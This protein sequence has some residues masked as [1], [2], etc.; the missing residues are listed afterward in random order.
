VLQLRPP[1]PPSRLD[2]AALRRVARRV[3]TGPP[4]P[5]GG[6]DAGPAPLLLSRLLSAASPVPHFPR[7]P[8]RHDSAVSW[9]PAARAADE[10][11][12][13]AAV[14]KLLA[15]LDACQPGHLAPMQRA[16]RELGRARLA[17][18]GGDPA[19]AA[20]FAAAI[21][22]LRELGTPTTS[23]TACSTTPAIS[24]AWAMPALWRLPSRRP[25]LSPV[26]CAD[27]RC[28]TGPPTSHL[29]IPVPS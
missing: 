14:G 12:D 26:T 29:Q 18:T 11:G 2:P 24:H 13:T 5:E 19:A 23:P 16:E 7:F 28:W 9:P 15:L 8:Q 3:P 25:A 27:S 20:S 6:A 22:G 4:R 10:L 1:D 21:G 17:A